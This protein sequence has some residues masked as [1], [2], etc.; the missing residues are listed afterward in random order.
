MRIS[1]TSNPP[2]LESENERAIVQ[3]VLDRR[4][5][6]GLWKLDRA[7]LHSPQTT[8]G[9][10]AFVG[11]IRNKTSLPADL[12]ETAFLRVAALCNCWYEWDIHSPIVRSA[13]I[14]EEGLQSI[15]KGDLESGW[16]TEQ[17]KAV[18]EYADAVTSQGCIVSDAHVE[19]LKEF[20]DEKQVVEMT[21]CIAGFNLVSRFIT[22]LDVG[23]K[24][25]PNGN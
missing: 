22:A 13:G 24:N 3:R 5:P 10:N 16:L 17:Q 1:Y 21:A 20:L 15:L 8:D 18:I 2:T 23:E 25:G 19:K 11:A 6:D 12:R 14:S 4:H 9:F 7:L